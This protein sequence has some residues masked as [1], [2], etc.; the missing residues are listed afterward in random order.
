MRRRTGCKKAHARAVRLCAVVDCVNKHCAHGPGRAACAHVGAATVAITT[1]LSRIQCRSMRAHRNRTWAGQN[2]RK[3]R[4]RTHTLPLQII[5]SIPALML[6]RTINV[7][8]SREYMLCVVCL[9]PPH[10]HVNA[11]IGY[12]LA[13]CIFYATIL[14]LCSFRVCSILSAS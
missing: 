6:F 2:S 5:L 10:V 13:I 1:Y 11:K 4:T 14:S 3:T 7:C 9:S 8:L 12:P